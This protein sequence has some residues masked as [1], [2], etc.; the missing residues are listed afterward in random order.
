[1]KTSNDLLKEPSIQ[2]WVYDYGTK[3]ATTK[4]TTKPADVIAP[5]RDEADLVTSSLDDGFRDPALDLSH[6]HGAKPDIPTAADPPPRESQQSLTL[7]RKP[8]RLALRAS[9]HTKGG[10]HS[11]ADDGQNRLPT[12]TR[13]EVAHLELRAG[14]ST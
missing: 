3:R 2:R 14:G 12:T 11:P 5:D 9:L 6:R 7:G 4:V 1:M 13:L 8:D 10:H